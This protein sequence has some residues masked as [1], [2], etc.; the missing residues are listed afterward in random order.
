M[1]GLADTVRICTAAAQSNMD[2]RGANP[3]ERTPQFARPQAHIYGRNDFSQRAYAE[4]RGFSSGREY[5]SRSAAKGFRGIA[6]LR[7]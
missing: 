7:R 1:A 5:G 3:Y 6:L 4:P 2:A